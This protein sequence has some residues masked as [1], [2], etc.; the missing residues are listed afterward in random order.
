MGTVVSLIKNG[1]GIVS[2]KKFMGYVDAVKKIPQCAHFRRGLLHIED[3]LKK[4][5]IY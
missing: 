3:F 5:R 1:A 2:L 4:R